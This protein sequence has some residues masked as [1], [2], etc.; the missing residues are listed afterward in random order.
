MK[1][2]EE[3]EEKEEIG[4]EGRDE[5]K[6][7]K[8]QKR[9]EDDDEVE[10]QEEEVV[11]EEDDELGIGNHKDDLYPLEDIIYYPLP[12]SFFQESFQL[13]HQL[14]NNNNY[15]IDVDV[16]FINQMLERFVLL[17]LTS[18]IHLTVFFNTNS[19]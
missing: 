12:Q 8:D 5:N 19:H 1:K 6:V 14:N 16:N 3:E 15:L 2:K 7:H 9:E 18:N 13:N 4:Q 17:S 10:G 11:D